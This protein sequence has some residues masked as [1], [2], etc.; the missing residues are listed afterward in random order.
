MAP[1]SGSGA[2]VGDASSGQQADVVHRLLQRKLG[3]EVLQRFD[4]IRQN[5]QSQPGLGAPNADTLFDNARARFGSEPVSPS[6]TRFFE[7]GSAA[8]VPIVTGGGGSIGATAA[9]QTIHR[10]RS[11]PGG[12]V[13]EGNAS[14]LEWVTKVR[15][16]PRLNAFVLGDN[17]VY[18]SPIPRDSA[19]VLA[20]ALAKEDLVGVSLG[21]TEIVY[22]ALPPESEVA[23]DL[24]VAD[25]FLGSIVFARS[26][27]IDA[28]RFANGFRPA[29]DATVGSVAVFFRFK[30]FQFAVKDEQ[31]LLANVGFDARIVP[32]LETRAADGG[33]L[34]DLNAIAQGGAYP[35]FVRNAE[36]IGENI[37]YYRREKIIDRAF[38][39]GEVAAFLRALK[40]E[41]ID[42]NQ[43]VLNIKSGASLT[44]SSASATFEEAWFAYL[45]DIQ[46]HNQYQN[47]TTAPYDAVISNLQRVHRNFVFEDSDRRSLAH[48]DLQNLS[49]VQ[50]RIARNEIFAR[51]GRYFKDDA[52]R[53]YFSQ[54]SWYRPY[55]WDVPLNA[56]EQANV[57]L[58]VAQESGLIGNSQSTAP[59]AQRNFIFADSS[60]RYLSRQ[61]LG[62]LNSSQLRIARNEIFARKGRYFK[63][64]A[65][66]TYFSQFSWYH[67]YAW[68]VP[69]NPIEAG[70]VRLIQ[71]LER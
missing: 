8:P 56:I 31:L 59:A 27:M 47:W 63:D 64:D 48:A 33:G 11:V 5:V 50:L 34:P 13:L 61:E 67:P 70:N 25:H 23:M 36:H 17:A 51:K 18:F 62:N 44:A 4:S 46:V 71:S 15:Y 58:I 35:E 37:N 45:K 53:S 66:R 16:E 41:G 38:A 1:S 21:K 60:V 39:Y 30:D 43:L 68:D 2:A 9:Q 57:S 55:A 65:L 29:R 19:A 69:L 54:F 24:K 28:Y 26:E 49:P 32:L 40:V 22:G 3:P 12:V 6:G 42:L 10:Y 20:A 52:L 7:G 14:G